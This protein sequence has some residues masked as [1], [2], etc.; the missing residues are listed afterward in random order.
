MVVLVWLS[1]FVLVAA[2]ADVSRLP[3]PGQWFTYAEVSFHLSLP[4]SEND[5]LRRRL[6]VAAA[7][8]RM[9]HGPMGVGGA[10]L[11]APDYTV[12]MLGSCDGAVPLLGSLIDRI[13]EGMPSHRELARSY[14]STARCASKRNRLRSPSYKPFIRPPPSER[15][16]LVPLGPR[17]T[18]ATPP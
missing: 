14:Y 9:R 15:L 5:L 4:I 3:K 8:E 10:L 7:T 16:R 17:P 13:S 1:S 6:I 18:S 12:Q 11:G 2:P